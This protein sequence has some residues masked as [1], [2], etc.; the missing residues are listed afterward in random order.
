MG[1]ANKG[2]CP[3]KAAGGRASGRGRTASDGAGSWLLARRCVNSGCRGARGGWARGGGGF[4]GAAGAG[5]VGQRVSA[6]S[7]ASPSRTGPE[8]RSVEAT[9]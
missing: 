6:A 1:L 4:V 5:L 8:G 7:E 2:R 3:I 9:G